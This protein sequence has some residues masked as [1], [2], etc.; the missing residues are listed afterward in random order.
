M[1][2]ELPEGSRIQC[3]EVKNATKRVWLRLVGR[4]HDLLSWA[5]DDRP[6]E[7]PK[8]HPGGPALR[9][10]ERFLD[11]VQD[12]ANLDAGGIQALDVQLDPAQVSPSDA[13][14]DGIF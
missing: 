4:R 2:G 12:L 1:F 14:T 8:Q 5:P 3:A 9:P 13:T 10:Y 6:M 11:L 7:L